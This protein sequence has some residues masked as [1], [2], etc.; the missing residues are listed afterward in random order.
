MAHHKSFIGKR[1]G[2]LVV[3]SLAK[4]RNSVIHVIAKCDCGF[5]GVYVLENIERGKITSCGCIKQRG[6]VY[7][8][9][10]DERV[11]ENIE[12]CGECLIWK[13]GF[14]KNNYKTPYLNCYGTQ[15]NP[16]KYLEGGDW[17]TSNRNI[18]YVRQCDTPL[19]VNPEHNSKVSRGNIKKAL[20]K[21][22]KCEYLKRT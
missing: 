14:R 17:K 21:E 10:V 3:I 19:C 9:I 7:S 8:K 11:M 2:Y 16:V 5:E 1:F 15:I 22:I 6:V 12:V 4:Y 18:V 13:G 20:K